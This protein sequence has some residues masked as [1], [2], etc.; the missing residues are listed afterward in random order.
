MSR[1]EMDQAVELCVAA[2]LVLDRTHKHPRVIQPSTGKFVSF[3]ST[4]NCSFAPRKMLRDVRRYLG[5]EVKA[6]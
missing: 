1:R 6:K 5:V 2:G 4:P 3:S